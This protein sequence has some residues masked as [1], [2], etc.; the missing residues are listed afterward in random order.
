MNLSIP[1]PGTM[2]FET[3][4]SSPRVSKRLGMRPPRTSL[5]EKDAVPEEDKV[6]N[7]MFVSS[8][9]VDLVVTIVGLLL[10][11]LCFYFGGKHLK[12]RDT[13]VFMMSFGGLFLVQGLMSSVIAGHEGWRLLKSADAGSANYVEQI[14]KGK[15][16][17]LPAFR[18]PKNGDFVM[19]LSKDSS[20]DEGVDF[21]RIHSMRLALFC[22]TFIIG[23]VV[24]S[25]LVWKFESKELQ[26]TTFKFKP[27]NLLKNRVKWDS[28]VFTT[29]PGKNMIDSLFIP[30]VLAVC[31]IMN[32]VNLT[33]T[34]LIH[35]IRPPAQHK[36]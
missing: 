24:C 6:A 29:E 32:V 3:L 36:A 15:K 5:A 35:D 11:F 14:N 28:D 31:V 1:A 18:I 26:N 8:F 10:S 23:I 22:I 20:K 30:I 13:A 17:L 12:D 25:M 27:L 21:S 19:Y 16:M 9:I 4:E 34:A 33:L 7:R 2:Q